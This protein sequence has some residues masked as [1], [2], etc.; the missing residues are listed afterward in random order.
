MKTLGVIRPPTFF[1]TADGNYNCFHFR[2]KNGGV[3]DTV[4]FST[5][6]LLPVQNQNHF[7]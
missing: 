1:N 5:Y 7:V 2:Y 3:N 6:Q 4:L